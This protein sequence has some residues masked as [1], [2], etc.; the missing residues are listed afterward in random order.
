MA[1]P[2]PSAGNSVETAGVAAQFTATHWSIVRAAQ[3]TDS[4]AARAALETLCRR[5]W[6]PLVL[7]P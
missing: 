7:F 1:F 2:M 3:Q 5:Y 4:E 6:Y